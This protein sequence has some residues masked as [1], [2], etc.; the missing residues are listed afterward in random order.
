MKGAE[1]F[2]IGDYD[3]W[4]LADGELR[5]DANKLKID[6]IAADVTFEDI[7]AL[8]SKPHQE[9]RFASAKASDVPVDGGRF[10]FQTE[11]W[12]SLFL[13]HCEMNWCGGIVHTEAVTFNPYRPEFDITLF[14]E[15][16]DLVQALSLVKEGARSQE[17]VQAEQFGPI[18]VR[19]GAPRHVTLV[20]DND[21]AEATNR[22]ES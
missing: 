12:E 13:E 5:W 7:I 18:H 2:R 20:I 15:H 19:A 14:A 10:V 9:I 3:C 4:T 8:R 16:V 22:T 17:V 21:R 11:S 6:G 1:R